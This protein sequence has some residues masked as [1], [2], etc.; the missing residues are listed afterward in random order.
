MII[1]R[2]HQSV[3]FEESDRPFVDRFGIDA[4]EEMVLDYA[5]FSNR[6]FLFDV[7]QLADFLGTDCHRLYALTN[8]CASH[9]RHFRIP[10]G[11]GGYRH[12][13][14]PKGTLKTIQR[15]ILRGILNDYPISPYATAYHQGASL[16]KNAEPH[17]HKEFVLKMDI[18][19]FFGSI[20]FQTVYNTVF[21]TRYFPVAI[22]TML[23]ELCCRYESLPQGAPTSPAISNIVMKFF[24]DVMGSWCG[25]RGIS[26]TRYCDDITFSGDQNLY[27]AYVKAK[28]LLESM[29]FE[30]NEEKTKF[31]SRNRRQ[32]ITGIVVNEVPKV[33]RDA[34]RKLRQE[35]YYFHKY[36]A[37]D[38]ILRNDLRDFL[39]EDGEPLVSRYISSLRS[40]VEYVLQIDRQDQE[41]LKEKELLRSL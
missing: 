20:S 1:D 35:L 18:V 40:R 25:R 34:R 9:Y 32:K 19:D 10:K 28:S 24:D 36:G 13:Y 15:K 22:G 12:L 31:I 6:P 41:F 8:H 7:Y 11:N 27:P 2:E 3:Q 4:A 37:E 23:T 17:C 33:P 29:R 14:A 16:Y 5:V 38:V 39:S 30:V 21:N 26:Y